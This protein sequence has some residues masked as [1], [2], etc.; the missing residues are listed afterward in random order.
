MLV[1]IKIK[2]KLFKK[3]CILTERLIILLGFVEQHINFKDRLK[4]K[5]FEPKLLDNS[6]LIF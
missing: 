4:A 2:E 3:N 5:C 6:K 1:Q